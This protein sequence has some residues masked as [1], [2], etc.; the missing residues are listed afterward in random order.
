MK[1]K[2]RFTLGKKTV[3][4]VLTMS[5][6]LCA[7][8]LF[9]SY[10]TYHARTTAFYEQLGYNVVKTLASQLDPKALDQYYETQTMDEQYY[11]V[12][13]FI[14]DLVESSEVEYLY[15]VRPH[16]VGVTFLFDS[17]METGENGDYASGG[18]CALGTYTDLVGS[19]AENL[20]RL[21]EG[22]SVE[23]I[24]QK[25]PSYGWMM[26]V[27]VPVLHENGT[28]AAYVMADFNL[29]DV[30]GAR[31]L[32]MVSSM[33]SRA[34]GSTPAIGSSSMYSFASR[35]MVSIS[36]SFSLLPLESVFMRCLRDIPSLSSRMSHFSL[37]KSLKKSA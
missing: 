31:F 3:L 20:D 16:G 21:L 29:E 35:D 28:M 32:S 12:Q 33:K 11:K 26:T 25:D 5:V 34:A 24:V 15:V 27:M 36:P 37:L 30:V 1:K 14:A 17:D 19:F 2:I 18:Y 7:T 4:M 13:D 10:R 23:P 22:E 6:I 9:I 8:A